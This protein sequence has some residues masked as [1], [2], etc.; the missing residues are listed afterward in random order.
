MNI[1]IK[2]IL[3]LSLLC[4]VMVSC[5]SDSKDEPDNPNNPSGTSKE[6][7]LTSKLKGTS[8]HID[9]ITLDNETFDPGYDITDIY[10]TYQP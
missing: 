7:P 1:F 9:R 6:H 2:K 8:W 4:V 3:L 10:F 5:G